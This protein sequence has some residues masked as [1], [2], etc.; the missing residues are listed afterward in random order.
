VCFGLG[1]EALFEE[2]RV[3]TCQLRVVESHC[4]AKRTHRCTV[5]FNIQKDTRHNMPDAISL[6]MMQNAQQ[7]NLQAIF[8][9]RACFVVVV[10][11]VAYLVT[12]I[13]GLS[14]RPSKDEPIQDPYFTTMEILILLMMIPMLVAM[15]AYRE[16]IRSTEHKT[17]GWLG[18]LALIFLI[19][20]TAI[21]SSVHAAVLMAN[22]SDALKQ[23]NQVLYDYIFSFN[24]PSVV[25]A[26]DILAW[27]WFFALSMIT[28]GFACNVGSPP[29][30][31]E[32]MIQALFITSGGLS[33]LG[34]IAVPMD[35][36]QIRIIGIVGYAVITIPLFFVLGIYIAKVGDF[37]VTTAEVQSNEKE[38]GKENDRLSHG[39]P[40]EAP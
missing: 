29:R 8:G 22:R 1:S 16:L 6:F 32:R 24:W 7:N 35:N 17:Q 40:L 36:I 2:L 13:A 33:L 30:R 25:Y 26:L 38:M 18:S 10:L 5:P 20:S 11:L 39:I 12:T 19:L 37:S 28:A 4:S 34:L 23:E 27:D 21:T 14:D 9:S 15:D 3:G 31:F